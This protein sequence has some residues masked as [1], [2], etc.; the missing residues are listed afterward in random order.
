MKTTQPVTNKR[1]RMD[2]AKVNNYDLIRLVAALQVLY[3]HGVE[4][5]QLRQPETLVRF[6]KLFPGV[7]VFFFLSG[8]LIS[9]SW[10]GNSR[11]AEYA[12][13]RCLRI[14]PAL[15]VC[16][17]VSVA[18]V[19]AVGYL[20]NDRAGI[21]KFVGW[22]IGQVTILQF[23]TPGFMR[24][25]GTGAL[26]GSLPTIT[27]EL[28]FYVLV[29]LMYHVLRLKHRPRRTVNGVLVAL[30]FVFLAA[31]TEFNRRGGQQTELNW[32]K[33]LNVSFIP[34]FY[35]FLLGVLVQRNMDRVLPF[36]R[37]R[38]LPALSVYI[39]VAWVA[40]DQFGWRVSNEIHPLLFVLLAAAVLACGY[41]KPDL[42]RQLLRRNDISYGVYLY[43]IPV[44]NV[45]IE[46]DHI[47]T[48][49][50]LFVGAVVAIALAVLSWKLLEQPLM[51]RKRHSVSPAQTNEPVSVSAST[52]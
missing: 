15:V 49:G 1:A 38:A 42:A 3:I 20:W 44:F 45:L 41:T 51:K 13:N 18:S 21:P 11:I 16:T 39:A 19:F 8:M 46:K 12:R 6:V 26:N 5:L 34:W 47:G 37:G 9:M 7:P 23:F 50:S 31:N 2:S 10:E 36:L 33:L 40:R 29:P 35:M 28:Q 30:I 48:N 17:L 52:R 25:Y 14:Y 24:E 32:M 22:V 43:H 27:T 4:H